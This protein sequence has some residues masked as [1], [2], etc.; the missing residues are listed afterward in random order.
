MARFRAVLREVEEEATA[1]A[2]GG[3]VKAAALHAYLRHLAD[4]SGRLEGVGNSVR[5]T[6]VGIVVSGAVETAT[7]PIPVPWSIV[8]GSTAG[9]IPKTVGCS[10]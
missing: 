9:A 6:A 10:I 5:R 4:A 7:L 3:D 1:E 8:V 2:A